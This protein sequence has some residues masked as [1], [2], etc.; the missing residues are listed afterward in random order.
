MVVY[1]KISVHRNQK[2]KLYVEK[3]NFIFFKNIFNKFQDFIII[4]NSLNSG[5]RT[6]VNIFQFSYNI[7]K[8]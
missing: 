5:Q 2:S 3:S 1:N 8:Y 6:L 7:Y 4:F